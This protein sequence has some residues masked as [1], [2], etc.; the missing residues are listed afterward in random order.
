MFLIE[1]KFTVKSENYSLR[2]LRRY[3]ARWI[4]VTRWT[5]DRA[6]QLQ[7]VLVQ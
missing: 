5:L 1:A 2:Q 4:L 6:P 7:R 3:P